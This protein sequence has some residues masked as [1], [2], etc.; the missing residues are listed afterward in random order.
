VSLSQTVTINGA[1]VNAVD[2][3]RVLDPTAQVANSSGQ[4]TVW[5]EPEVRTDFTTAAVAMLQSPPAKFRLTKFELPVNAKGGQ[6]P[7]QATFSAVST[8][9]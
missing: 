9:V 5:V 1:S 4:V 8:Y 3:H 6:R 7:G 2:L